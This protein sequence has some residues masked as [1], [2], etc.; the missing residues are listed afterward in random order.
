MCTRGICKLRDKIMVHALSL[1]F[2]LSARNQ[3][4]K[5]FISVGQVLTHIL[6][7]GL[8]MQVQNV[9]SGTC[10]VRACLSGYN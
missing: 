3:K 2:E 10:S 7:I 8:W 9:Q 1:F 4:K 6:N 5:L